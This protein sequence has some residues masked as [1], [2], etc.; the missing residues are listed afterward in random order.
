MR[1]A[2]VLFTALAV[3]FLISCKMETEPHV[4]TFKNSTASY[5]FPTSL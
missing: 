5:F 2:F 4:V 1:R 3:L